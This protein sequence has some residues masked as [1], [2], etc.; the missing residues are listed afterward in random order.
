MS[1]SDSNLTYSHILDLAKYYDV[2]L[3]D[4]WGVLVESGKNYDGVIETVNQL[5]KNS[6]VMFLTNAPRPSEITLQMLLGWGINSVKKEDIIT[7]GD[8]AR[9]LIQEKQAELNDRA[10]I[11]HLGND[12]NQDILKDMDVIE[13]NNIDEAD[14]LLLS[15]YRD[16]HENIHEFD[17]LLKT[18]AENGIFT[19]C[20]NPDTTIPQNGALR[21]CA[22]HFASIME[23]YGANIIYSGKPKKIIYDEALSRCAEHHKSKIIMIGDTLDTDILGAKNAGIASAIVLTGNAEKIHKNYDNLADKIEAIRQEA[24]KKGL[25]P[26]YVTSLS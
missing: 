8:V 9:M 12:R 25:Q 3:F 23:E 7:S 21:Y 22:G 24:N 11:Y 19:I 20:S 2:F 4:L 6:K 5:K 13:T 14:V 10:K 15:L 17:D 18:A 26:N 16:E 1:H